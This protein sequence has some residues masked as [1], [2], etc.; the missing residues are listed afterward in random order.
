MRGSCGWSNADVSPLGAMQG[1]A[2]PGVTG[3]DRQTHGVSQTDMP[4]TNSGLLQSSCFS[5]FSSH[6]PFGA[7]ENGS[8]EGPAGACG[9]AAQRS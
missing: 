2:G 6:R 8:L 3:T 9:E 4:A 7:S 1:E 5:F